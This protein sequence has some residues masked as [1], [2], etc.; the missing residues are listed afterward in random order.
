MS[1]NPKNILRL[2]THSFSDSQYDVESIVTEDERSFAAYLEDLIKSSVGSNVF[3]ET[4]ET[5]CYNDDSV[6]PDAV[7]VDDDFEDDF[8]CVVQGDK[9]LKVEIGVDYKS[10][11]VKFWR[12]AKNGNMNFNTVKSRFKKVPDRK[13]L[14][15]WEAQVAEGGTRNEKLF[16]IS[17]YVLD[18]FK[19]AMEKSLSVHDFDLKRW[20]L[21]AR[22]DVKLSNKLFS[23]SSKWIHTFKVKH[24]IVS[25]KINKFV[26]KTQITSKETLVQKS[27][28]FVAT[29]RSEMLSI[30]ENNIFNSDQSGFNLESHAGR[31]LSFKGTLKVE[32]LAQ[33]INSLTHSYTIQPFISASGILK[34]PLLIVLQ[35]TQGKFGPTVSNNIYKAENILVLASK[36]GKL[37]SDLVMKWLMLFYL[38]LVKHRLYV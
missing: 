16:C 27:N 35:E 14:Y 8:E 24:G 26:T 15:R 5:L 38:M 6:I 36:S 19:N 9:K 33:S 3:T 2:L 34:S 4:Y 23:A 28:E 20:A 18:Q 37:S 1:M 32:C 29:V 25:R 22:D 21:K 17:T 12:S 10:K 30:G 13:T 31:T 7:E 11:A